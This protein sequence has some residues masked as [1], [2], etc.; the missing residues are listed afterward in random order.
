MKAYNAAKVGSVADNVLSA[1]EQANSILSMLNG[2]KIPPVLAVDDKN[3]KKAANVDK[4]GK[5]DKV[6]GTVDV[7]S[8]DLK[9]MRD[10][11]ENDI[12][13]EVY[14]S[15]ITPQ[16]NIQFGDVRETADVDKIVSQI[17]GKI[18]ESI[19]ISPEGLH[20]GV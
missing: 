16:V 9:R 8:E 14:V 1:T 10:I 2:A 15:N 13:Q 12:I 7:S 18:K 19:S 4:V 17:K 20:Q 3:K 6:G 5:V 11:Y